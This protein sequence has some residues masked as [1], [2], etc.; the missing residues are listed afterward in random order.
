MPAAYAQEKILRMLSWSEKCICVE[1]ALPLTYL[2][3]AD[4]A[5]SALQFGIQE[6]HFP[7]ETKKKIC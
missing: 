2:S 5:C 1:L 3:Y 7:G 4:T 6:K